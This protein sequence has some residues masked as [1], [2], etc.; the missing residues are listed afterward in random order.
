MHLFESCLFEILQEIRY[1]YRKLRYLDLRF[2]QGIKGFDMH[3][4]FSV[5]E[6]EKE[7]N[8]IRLVAVE[9]MFSNSLDTLTAAL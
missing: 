8:S 6:S 4:S 3:H 9:P 7:K 2:W 5:M 1:M